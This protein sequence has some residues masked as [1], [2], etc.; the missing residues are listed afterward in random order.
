M[1]LRDYKEILKAVQKKELLLWCDKTPKYKGFYYRVVPCKRSIA[2][3]AI[4][5]LHSV[6]YRI[7]LGIDPENSYIEKIEKK[8]SAC[9][10]LKYELAEETEK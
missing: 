6:K 8:I 2:V 9:D 4:R 3:Y 7:H 10:R 1:K 5:Y